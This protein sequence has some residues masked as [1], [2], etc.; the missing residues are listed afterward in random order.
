MSTSAGE[1][2]FDRLSPEEVRERLQTI[3]QSSKDGA[4]TV[5]RIQEFS[6]M[7][8]D[9]EFTPLSLNELITSAQLPDDRINTIL[10]V[11]SAK[12][13]MLWEKVFTAEPLEFHGNNY[14]AALENM[15]ERRYE[16]CK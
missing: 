8:R 7:R 10:R 12:R 3:E 2:Q 1:D 14:H 4:E 9:K 11:F 5:R 13:Q 16:G 15:E 6:G